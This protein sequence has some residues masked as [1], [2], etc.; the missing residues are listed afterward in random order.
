MANRGIGSDVTE[1]YINRINDIFELEPK[2][3]F[4]EGGVND[5]ARNIPEDIII[6]I[7]P[8]W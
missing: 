3:C 4:I 8:C 2:I 5:L 1:G 7:F 6:E